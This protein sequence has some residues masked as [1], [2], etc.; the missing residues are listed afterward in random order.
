MRQQQ[1]RLSQPEWYKEREPGYGQK[2]R[3][4]LLSS[5]PWAYLLKSRQADAAKR[6]IAFELTDEWA[7]ARWT[8]RC[9]IT[10]IAFRI[11]GKRGPSP[12]SPSIDRIDANK[13]YA[14]DNARFVLWGCNAL[15]GVG[16]DIDMLEIAEAIVRIFHKG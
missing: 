8:G 12:F 16:S 5:R 11:N 13:G 15:K 2:H 9:E 1:R 14:Q 6:G 3:A 7:R 4:K 10:S